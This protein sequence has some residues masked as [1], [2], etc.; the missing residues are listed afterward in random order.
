MVVVDTHA[1]IW[2][3]APT[4]SQPLET[5]VSG[6]ADISAEMLQ[7]CLDEH[8]VD[9]AVLVQPVYPG[10][11]NSYVA[12]TAASDP[13]RFAAV[14]VVDPRKTDAAKSLAYWVTDRGCRGLRL[15]PRIEAER[16]A[17]GDV[18]TFPMWEA[19]ESLRIAVS[20]LCEFEHLAAT[21][22]LAGLFPSVPIVIDH[23]AL[24]HMPMAVAEMQPLLDLSRFPCVYPKLSG[25]YFVSE[26]PHPHRDCHDL[27]RA[28]YD[29]FGPDRLLWGSDFP[30]VTA[31]S[32]YRQALAMVTE[33][34]DWLTAD[35][36]RQILGENAPRLYWSDIK[37]DGEA[38]R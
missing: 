37:V 29:R 17:F 32:S 3:P 21:V 22:K 38:P 23:L 25:F 9:R 7:Q 2:R 18:S 1:H 27:A 12:D 15:R 13:D 33:E 16:Q 20:L 36:R 35:D 28:V 10:E 24:P 6:A 19:A 8:G 11:D 5:I 4:G 31:R 30:H 34:F 14:C 26:V